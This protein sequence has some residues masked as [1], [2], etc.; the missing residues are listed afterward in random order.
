MWHTSNRLQGVVVLRVPMLLLALA[1][2]AY[3]LVTPT[4]R[5]G[6]TLFEIAF[7]AWFAL[8]L[9][10]V[11]QDTPENLPVR[12]LAKTA[13]FSYTLYLTHFPVLLFIFGALADR[14]DTGALIAVPAAI[15]ALAIATIVGKVERVALIPKR[16]PGMT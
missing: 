14:R 9:A 15:C 2:A 10:R 4:S 12:T 11:L 16:R 6:M 8:H 1:L 7:G 13:R 5:Y 3:L